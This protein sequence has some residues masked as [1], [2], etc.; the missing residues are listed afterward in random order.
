[1]TRPAWRG[2]GFTLIELVV[3][4]V[5]LAALGAGLA[6][7]FIT[8]PVASADPQIRAQA[9]AIAEGYVEEIML[10]A[11]SDPDGTDGETARENYDDV[12]DYNDIAD[13]QDPMDQNGDPMADGALTDYSVTVTVGDGATSDCGNSGLARIEVVVGHTTDRVNYELVSQRAEY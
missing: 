7:V 9:R 4:I 6:T 5:A 11:F 8:G 13:P 12:C 2:S 10:K 3:S 1:M